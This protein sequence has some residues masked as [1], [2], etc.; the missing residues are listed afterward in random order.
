[1]KQKSLEF[2]NKSKIQYLKWIILSIVIMYFLISY[3][4]MINEIELLIVLKVKN[5]E[6]N[7]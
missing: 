1:M 6:N 3:S 5:S 4:N 2:Y 7:K